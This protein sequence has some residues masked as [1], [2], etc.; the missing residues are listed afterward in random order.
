MDNETVTEYKQKY[1][2]K[3]NSNSGK[4]LQLSMAR[5]VEEPEEHILVVESEDDLIRKVLT[6]EVS[7]RAIGPVF[8][9]ENET[10]T[11]GEKSKTLVLKELT[12]RLL[13]IEN[14]PNPNVDISI[15]V[16]KADKT[17]EIKA[18][19]GIIRKNMN[20]ADIA[21]ISKSKDSG[22]LNLYFTRKND[23]DYLI[24]SI[25]VDP[26]ILLRNQKLRYRLP[27]DITKHTQI[28]NISIFTRPIFHKYSLQVLDKVVKSDYYM[29]KMQPLQVAH[30]VEECHI[31][32]L[33]DGTKLRLQSF[34][35]QMDT[36][37]VGSDFTRFLVCDEHIDNPVGV[38]DVAREDLLSGK[39]HDIDLEFNWPKKPLIIYKARGLVTSYLGDTY[40]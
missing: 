5:L 17:I 23:P 10:W 11:V 19:Y 7:R 25:Q 38:F 16:Y 14:K 21:D 13:R 31:A 39:T 4:I 35:S 30:K 2:V 20:L 27:E 24:D 15:K 8:D 6:G 1:Y 29:D 18:N 37:I 36:T 12:K 40:G 33:R 9:V 32:L 26:M 28:D 22:L 3:F 34:I